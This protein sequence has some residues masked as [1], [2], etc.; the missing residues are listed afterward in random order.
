MKT[1]CI[2]L[3]AITVAVVGLELAIA[4]P[5]GTAFTYQGRLELNGQ[6]VS[7]AVDA[8]FTLYDAATAGSAFGATLCFDGQAGDPAPIIVENGQFTVKLDFGAGVFELS[9][10]AVID[11]I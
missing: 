5:M 11:I 10:P 4:A 2:T 3:A 8:C 1:K 6:P 9:T 7:E